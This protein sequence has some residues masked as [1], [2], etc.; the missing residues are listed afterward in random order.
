MVMEERVTIAPKKEQKV[1]KN[2][3]LAR[4]VAFYLPQFHPIPENDEWWG[5]GFTE[6]TNVAKAKPLYRGHHQPNLPADLGFYDL[7]VPE[8]RL[9]QAQLAQEYGVEA[10]CYWHY[11][12]GDGQR[13][14]ERPFNEVLQSRQP[15]F[16]FCLAWANRS[17]TGIW[18]GAPNRLLIKQK[19]PGE[20]DYKDHFYSLLE[21]FYDPRYLTVDGQ[22]LFVVFDPMN[23]PDPVY[24]TNLW[25][26]LASKESFGDLFFVGVAN[27][28]NWNPQK[29]GFD[30]TT[31]N[32]PLLQ[33]DNL[34]RGT[35][36]NYYRFLRYLG[37]KS[38]YQERQKLRIYEYKDI[39]DRYS[40]QPLREEEYPL[41]LPNWD[42]TSRSGYRGVVI[43]N[44]TP[45]LFKKMLEKAIDRIQ[46]RELEQKIIFVKSWNEWAEGNY[47]EPDRRFGRSY[48]EVIKSV[49]TG[50]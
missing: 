30:A 12:F 37:S 31:L 10:F 50:Y 7:R 2:K 8:V 32:A 28:L 14:L 1:E 18:H 25:R 26:E 33:V 3:Q 47:L 21:A 20:R 35:N 16:P 36:K 49:V 5:K 40:N 13:L 34:P 22:K 6:W 41:V 48:L 19:Y 38:P 45:E 46:N 15:D 43:Q 44:S 27:K 29:H 11:W 17:W 39:V 9:A 23:L 4:L 42:N 24:F